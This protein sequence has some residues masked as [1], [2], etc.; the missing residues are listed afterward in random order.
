[1][2]AAWPKTV[3]YPLDENDIRV[4]EL[5]R[6]KNPHTAKNGVEAIRHALQ[7]YELR[8][9]PKPTG[10][11]GVEADL[12]EIKSRL[13]GAST[14]EIRALLLEILLEL[15]SENKQLTT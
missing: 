14:A 10:R 2:A 7:D 13:E 11:G 15:R 4:L 5:I 12:T 3:T 9:G 6:S 1:M 8:H